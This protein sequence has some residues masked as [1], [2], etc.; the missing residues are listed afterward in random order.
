VKSRKTSALDE[1]W[2]T[3]SHTHTHTYK[4]EPLPS[5]TPYTV[6]YLEDFSL[7]LCVHIG[8]SVP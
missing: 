4:T 1:M 3:N 6:L 2:S 7:L 5:K 8:S